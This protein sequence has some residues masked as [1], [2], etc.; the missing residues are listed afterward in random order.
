MEAASSASEAGVSPGR[1]SQQ[2]AVSEALC[3]LGTVVMSSGSL[4]L[5]AYFILIRSF[6]MPLH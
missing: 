5:V 2:D 4:G 3:V 1:R 6:G